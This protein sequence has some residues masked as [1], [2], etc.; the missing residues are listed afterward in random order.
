MNETGF[1]SLILKG[2]TLAAAVCAAVWFYL[3]RPTV[4]FAGNQKLERGEVYKAMDMVVK[5]NGEVI[6]VTEYLNTDEVGVFST[7][8]TVKKGFF[9][10][11]VVYSYEVQDTTPPVIKIIDRTVYMDPGQDYNEEEMRKNVSVNEGTLRLETECKPD[12]A[13]TYE[14]YVLAED[15][16]GNLSTDVYNV[17]VRDVE[18]PFIFRSG[19][20]A[21]RVRGSR[22]DINDVIS[23]GDNADPA[24]VLEIEGTVNTSRLG[25]YPLHAKLTD[26][27]GNETEW[28]LRVQVVRSLPDDDYPDDQYEFSDFLSDYAGSGR[29]FGI[30]VSEWQGEIDFEKIKEAGCEF[31]FMRMGFSHEGD[32]TLDKEFKRNIDEANKFGMPAGIYLF[33][34]DSTEQQL[35]STLYWMFQELEGYDIDLPIVFDWENF[36]HFQTYGMSFQDLNHLYD[37]FEQEVNSRGYRSML[38]GSK[39]YLQEIWYDTDTRPVWL[40]QYT[41]WPS[42]QGE[43]EYWQVC[44]TGRIDGIDGYVDFDI[45]FI[46]E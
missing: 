6:P 8:Y 21:M 20:G 33:C 28:D 19:D 43:Y 25:Y 11:N 1:K 15:E 13:G 26:A 30:D 9:E 42:Y 44:D 18:P 24:P 2:L 40:A 34:Y 46:K 29:Y 23:Y 10:R 32:L 37:V 22:F 45:G 38:Y 7:S 27:S 5:T 4:E 3:L 41:D 36:R 14:V 16:Y 35:R 39:Y 12:L 17:V 31:V